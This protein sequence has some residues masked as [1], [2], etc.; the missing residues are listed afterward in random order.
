MDFN[1]IL[2]VN[3]AG[4]LAFCMMTPVFLAVLIWVYPKV[5]IALLRVNALAGVIIGIFNVMVV[6]A[7]PSIYWWFGAL[8]IPLFVL[9]MY[10]LWLGARK[11]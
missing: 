3:N 8:H 6:F 2:L 4:G 11:V 7:N 5:N 9:G 1:P 10:G